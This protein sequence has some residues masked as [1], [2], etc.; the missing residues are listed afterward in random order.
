MNKFLDKKVS[1]KS[2]LI[3]LLICIMIPIGMLSFHYATT[4]SRQG[5]V[6]YAEE[7]S[8]VNSKSFS[9]SDLTST[10]YKYAVSKDKNCDNEI[11][12]FDDV[13]PVIEQLQL[14]G[15]RVRRTDIVSATSKKEVGSLQWIKPVPYDDSREEIYLVYYSNNKEEIEKCI[16]EFTMEGTGY[17][18]NTYTTEVRLALGEPFAFA[19]P[20]VEDHG[21]NN[22]QLIKASFYNHY[23]ELVYEDIP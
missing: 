13:Y 15:D 20:L 8:E 5:M 4:L 12:L 2:I 1:V 21:V 7:K 6:D 22:K 11:F 3:V 18:G 23:N 19:I 14:G 16:Y 17:E 9:I 10:G